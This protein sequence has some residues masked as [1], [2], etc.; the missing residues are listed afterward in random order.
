M[1][2]YFNKDNLQLPEMVLTDEMYMDY[3]KFMNFLMIEIYA[4]IFQ[5]RLPRVLLEMWDLLQY[6]TKNRT[7][8]WFF[9][10]YETMT[11]IYGFT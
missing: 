3:T 4:S 8:D 1:F 7:G 9:L 10:E 6:S 2:L 11:R 5:K